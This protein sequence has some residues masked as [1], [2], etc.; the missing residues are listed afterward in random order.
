MAT[1][2]TVCTANRIKQLTHIPLIRY[3]PTSP[4]S[5][6][7]AGISTGITSSQLDMRRKAEI[8]KYESNRMPNQTNNLTKK[9]KWSRLI[10]QPQRGSTIQ[11]NTDCPLD[12]S[13]R[14]LTTASDVPGRPM[15]LYEDPAIPLY[16][17][18]I[19]RTY[20]YNVPNPNSYWETTVN[21]NVGL[22]N[23]MGAGIFSLN[24]LPNINKS[25]YSYNLSIPF[26]IHVGGTVKS[27]VSITSIPPIRISITQTVLTVFCNGV[28][29][30]QKVDTATKP[31][32]EIAISSGITPDRSFGATQM[33]GTL[34][35][36]GIQLNTSPIYV[37]DFALAFTFSAT[38]PNG[39][40][41]NTAL[42]DSFAYYAY[43]N[44]T[45]VIDLS[46]TNCTVNSPSPAIAITEPSLFGA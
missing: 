4:Y 25:D 33:I 37:F 28:Q 23:G 22:L 34:N 26:G 7:I 46:A 40:A 42:F 31:Y 39:T 36:T 38:Y 15:Y 32:F 19:S 44:I 14:V 17:Y 3:T 5:N 16:N 29:I 20:A 6:P 30:A 1:D 10:T 41:V 9:Q 2:Q 43:A 18:I 45:N 8:L 11:P 24:I 35:Y 12:A 27:S 21:T 13:L